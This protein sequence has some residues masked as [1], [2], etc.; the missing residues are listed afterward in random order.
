MKRFRSSFQQPNVLRLSAQ[1]SIKRSTGWYR[2]NILHQSKKKRKKRKKRSNRRRRRKK[3]RFISLYSNV[4]IRKALP[5]PD[6]LHKQS[7]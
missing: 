3:I 2:S 7:S 6:N 1:L 4:S 5:K